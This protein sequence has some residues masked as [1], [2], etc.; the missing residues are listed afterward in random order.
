[1]LFSLRK[2]KIRRWII[3]VLCGAFTLVAG[4]S[5]LRIGYSTAPDL[6]YWWLDRYV[7]FNGAQ[8]V[9]VREAIGAWFTWNRRTQLPDYAALLARAQVEVVAD[10]TAARV[11]EWQAEL[12]KRAITAADRAT[13]AAAEILLTFSP[14][15]I[16][17]IERRY[18]A[19]NDDF[20]DDYL[21][22]DTAKR[23]AAALKRT[24]ERAETLYG[25]LDDAQRA[26]MAAALARSP[27]DAELWLN[28]RRLRQ[29]DAL[30][31]LRTLTGDKATRE[32][33]EAA[34][35]A[36]V[37]KIEHSP[38]EAYRRYAERLSEF[39]CA[40]AATLHNGTSVAQRRHAAGQLAGWE[41]D[42]RA[43]AKAKEPPA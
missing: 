12:I 6:V 38:R 24:V 11:C 33:A 9:R 31:L 43:L 29:Q 26:R 1:M 22:P 30:A 3:A 18:A 34:L 20:R 16:A 19:V 2:P 17:H 28:E 13:P 7:D 21:E 15:Q 23:A 10:T 4:C 36:Y 5:A 35:R 37:G 39:N 25:T 32:Q 27:F 14:Q 41:A 42:L 8:T 40:F